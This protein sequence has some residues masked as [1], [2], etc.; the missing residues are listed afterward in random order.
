MSN[1]EKIAELIKMTKTIKE[2]TE[3]ELKAL[4]RK[5]Y[6]LQ[7]QSFMEEHKEAFI[8][9][10]QPVPISIELS[11]YSEYDDEGGTAPHVGEVYL[12]DENNDMLDLDFEI[13]VK[14]TYD[15]EWYSVL[16]EEEFQDFLSENFETEDLVK[17]IGEEKITF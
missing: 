12:Y 5:L 8:K 10:E 13:S 11:F 6:K 2:N 7:V 1:Q 3:I 17:Y 9:N 4:T 16:I 15:E 14:S